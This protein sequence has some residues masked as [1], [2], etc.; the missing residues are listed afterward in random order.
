MKQLT[1]AVPAFT[2]EQE[3]QKTLDSLCGKDSRM[4]ILVFFWSRDGKTAQLIKQFEEHFPGQIRGAASEDGGLGASVRCAFELSEGRYLKVV[5]PG[6][7]IPGQYLAPVLD[8]LEDCE[9]DVFLTGFLVPAGNEDGSLEAVPNLNCSGR[10]IDMIKF[11]EKYDGLRNYLGLNCLC[12]K[13]EYIKDCGFRLEERLSGDDLEL[14]ILPFIRAES[15]FIEQKPFYEYDKSALSRERERQQ[16][17]LPF[18][19]RRIVE[20]YE[21][22]RP[23]GKARNDFLKR[24]ISE[25]INE[26]YTELMLHSPDVREGREEAELLHLWLSEISPELTRLTDKSFRSLRR[27]GKYQFLFHCK[28]RTP[29]VKS[30]HV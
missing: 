4:E 11:S 19:I 21:A 5:E 24:R 30:T 27:L 9:A 12:F 20:A 14:A 18:V 25:L 15:M 7:S 13:T 3:L 16:E 2:E 29:V 17:N 6:D 28:R 1:V 26:C 22:A 10:Q 23:M 8:T